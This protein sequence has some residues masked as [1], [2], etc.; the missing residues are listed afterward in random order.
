M[1][2][3]VDVLVVGGCQCGPLC[4][5]RNV[6]IKKPSCQLRIRKTRRR[7]L[8]THLCRTWWSQ[9]WWRGGTQVTKSRSSWNTSWERPQNRFSTFVRIGS[10][11]SYTDYLW[12]RDKPWKTWDQ[13]N[14][15]SF[16][17]TAA[18][19]L[20]DKGDVYLDPE[21]FVHVLRF[22]PHSSLNPLKPGT[23]HSSSRSRLLRLHLQVCM[24]DMY[25][26]AL[27]L[28]PFALDQYHLGM[29]MRFPRALSIRDDLSIHDCV[30]ATGMRP[31]S[32][33]A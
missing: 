17:Q 5:S 26:L 33:V 2:E 8:D 14:S 15:P 7:S 20:E 28:N 32:F 16:L 29:T 22:K 21:E 23:V 12:I 31:R 13:Q 25:F 9:F 4:V 18:R 24:K 11:F 3:T 27:C 30:T 1:G 10:G 19:S 6:L